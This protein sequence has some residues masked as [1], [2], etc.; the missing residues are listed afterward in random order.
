MGEGASPGS[1]RRYLTAAGGLLA[2]L[3][4]RIIPA[5]PMV[6]T[7]PHSGSDLVSGNSPAPDEQSRAPVH[8]DD[9]DEQRGRGDAPYGVH[10]VLQGVQLLERLVGHEPRNRERYHPLGRAEVAAGLADGPDEGLAPLRRGPC[11][12]SATTSDRVRAIRIGATPRNTPG[13]GTTRSTAPVT[14]PSGGYHPGP[15]EAASRPG[16]SLTVAYRP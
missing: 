7:P 3:R 2:H 5:T 16:E 4:S 13:G 14:A 8:L 11:P 6:K 15:D 9:R 10:H 12:G 1:F